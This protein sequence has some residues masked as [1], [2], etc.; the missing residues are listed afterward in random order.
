VLPVMTLNALD[1][2]LY[3]GNREKNHDIEA[4]KNNRFAR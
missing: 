2:C 3:I 1:T 4:H